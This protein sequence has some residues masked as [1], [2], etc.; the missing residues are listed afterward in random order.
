MDRLPL[1]LVILIAENVKNDEGSI[2]NLLIVNRR[3]SQALIHL[4]FRHVVLSSDLAVQM[5]AWA[6]RVPRTNPGRFVQTLKVGK[7]LRPFECGAWNLKGSTGERL[8]F[9][10]LELPRLRELSIAGSATAINRCLYEP[11]IPFKLQKLELPCANSR[12]LDRFLSRQTEIEHLRLVCVQS[13]LDLNTC[14]YIATNLEVLP[15]LDSFTGPMDWLQQIAPKR[16]LSEIILDNGNY[17]NNPMPWDR[18]ASQT[19]LCSAGLYYQAEYY[20][21]PRSSNNYWGQ[22][23]TITKLAVYEPFSGPIGTS[24]QETIVLR[25][26]TLQTCPGFPRLERLVI[27]LADDEVRCPLLVSAWLGEMVHLDNWRKHLPR[28]RSAAAYSVEI[29]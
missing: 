4:V 6:V 7:K 11:R 22:D 28:L 27:H 3:M 19:P 18:Y 1:E 23:Q 9:A 10:L 15:R 21:M 14:N 8:R 5:F 26:K 16:A 2:T 29:V 12:A 24:L 13:H 25:L 20:K 17:Y